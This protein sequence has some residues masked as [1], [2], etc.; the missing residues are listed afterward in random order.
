[1]QTSNEAPQGMRVILP[2]LEYSDAFKSMFRRT[3]SGD[4]WMELTWTF[5]ATRFHK[6]L[7]GQRKRRAALLR[8]GTLYWPHHPETPRIVSRISFGLRT[9]NTFSGS[10][11]GHGASLVKEVGG[12]VEPKPRRELYPRLSHLAATA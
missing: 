11:R 10:P 6:P 9:L 5:T 1:M 8:F 4:L 2:D 3:S 12:C 7:S